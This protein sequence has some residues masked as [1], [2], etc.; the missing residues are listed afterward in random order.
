MRAGQ[1]FGTLLLGMLAALGLTAC[2]DEDR[3]VAECTGPSLGLDGT[4]FGA[5]EDDDG[6]LFTLEWRVCGDT[7]SREAIS[8]VNAGI[9]GWLRRVGPDLFAAE[10]SDGTALRLLT[11]PQRR[12]AVVVSEFFEF[13]VLERSATR[14]PEYYFTDLDGG[15][16]GRHAWLRPGASSTWGAWAFCQAGR[17]DIDEDVGISMQL[18]MNRFDGS[19]GIFRGSF[20]DS[21][22][23]TGIAGA[24]ISADLRFM[25]TYTCVF[26]YR[27][28]EDCI[29]GAMTWD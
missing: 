3:L 18:D 20:D 25:G 1:R 15:W 22:G 14:L 11:D 8:G 10:L 9:N 16:A 19:F 13:A 28:P 12:Y 6:T 21:L 2:G 24:M 29:F 5:M 7:I 4:W 27:G 23:N 17:C 26:D